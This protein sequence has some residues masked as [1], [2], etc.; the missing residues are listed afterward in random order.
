MAVN[1]AIYPIPTGSVDRDAV[2]G[3]QLIA[4]PTKDGSVG[5][6]PIVDW[7][8]LS[9]VQT[10]PDATRVHSQD[11]VQF[12]FVIFGGPG[13]QNASF[14]TCLTSDDS[15]MIC[16]VPPGATSLAVKRHPYAGQDCSLSISG[17]NQPGP[18]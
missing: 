14:G 11:A 2:A 13:I 12:N 15:P 7:V 3:S 8:M 5:A 6:G 17:L 1:V 16:R 4:L 18:P 10:E 9:V